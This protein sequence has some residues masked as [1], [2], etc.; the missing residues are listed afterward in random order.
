MENS[1]KADNMPIL[2]LSWIFAPIVSLF[3]MN[4]TDE[5]VRWHAKQT[6][7]FGLADIG[8]NV[9]FFVLTFVLGIT[10]ILAP[11]AICVGLFQFIWTLVSL[12]VR[13]YGAAQ[14]YQGKRWEVPVI[15]KYIK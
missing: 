4:S 15:S 1:A 5:E 11:I 2:V 3:V 10:L 6:L 9:A 12:G 8:I 14:A 7:Y 13:I